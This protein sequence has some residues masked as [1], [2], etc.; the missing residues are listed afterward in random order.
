MSSWDSIVL[1]LVSLVPIQTVLT[2]CNLIMFVRVV[3][4]AHAFFASVAPKA[5]R[6]PLVS[7]STRID[8]LGVDHIQPNAVDVSIAKLMM[9]DA[10]VEFR[11]SDARRPHAAQHVECRTQRFADEPL[12]DYYV[13][14]PHTSYE[15]CAEQTVEMGADE[16]GILLPRS[17]LVRNAIALSSGLFDSGYAGRI[18]CVLTNNHSRPAYLAKTRFAQIVILSAD[19][20]ATYSGNYGRAST[21][22]HIRATPS[23]SNKHD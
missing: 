1:A 18:T 23:S 6:H 4:R 9:I 7:A 21:F 8:A 3:R 22:D 2:L 16:V 15:C 5:V 10:S 20:Y 11:L 14:E 12:V 17:T 19:A 13:L